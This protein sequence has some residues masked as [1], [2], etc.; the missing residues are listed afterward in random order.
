M[1]KLSMADAVQTTETAQQNKSELG[2]KPTALQH[3]HNHWG[4]SKLSSLKVE[5]E[6]TAVF[7]EL[8]SHIE[9][10]INI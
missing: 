3:L 4:S 10:E 9:Q 1:P 7:C 5:S 2:F 6:G 8:G